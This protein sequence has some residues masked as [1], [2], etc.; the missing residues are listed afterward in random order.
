MLLSEYLFF[1]PV[2]E[3][4]K[5]ETT[6]HEFTNRLQQ[7]FFMKRLASISLLVVGIINISIAVSFDKQAFHIILGGALCLGFLIPLNYAFTHGFVETKQD[8][9]ITFTKNP[10]KYGFIFFILALGFIAGIIAP[11]VL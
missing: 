1:E 2:S 7:W 4:S 10:L 5:Y 8:G 9:I 3:K 6:P 11:W